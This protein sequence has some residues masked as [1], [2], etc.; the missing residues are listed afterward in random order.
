MILL[1]SR[2]TQN[3]SLFPHRR[4]SASPLPFAACESGVPS[5]R[6]K[7]VPRGKADPHLLHDTD[8]PDTSPDADADA[9]AGGVDGTSAAASSMSALSVAPLGAMSG[10]GSLSA[11]CSASLFTSVSSMSPEDGLVSAG[12]GVAVSNVRTFCLGCEASGTLRSR[13]RPPPRGRGC[14]RLGLKLAARREVIAMDASC[15]SMTWSAVSISMFCSS[16]SGST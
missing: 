15:D 12:G 4:W 14:R 5:W 2:S 7:L 13:P 1:S 8:T 6:Q 3:C 9:D 10:G 11:C 16:N